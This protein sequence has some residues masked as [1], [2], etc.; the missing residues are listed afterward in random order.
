MQYGCVLIW[1]GCMYFGGNS[2]CLGG[3]SLGQ[4]EPPE[5]GITSHSSLLPWRIPWTREAWWLIVHGV[6]K[7]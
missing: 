4:E 7:S 2:D 6:A 5:K 1:H 3:R